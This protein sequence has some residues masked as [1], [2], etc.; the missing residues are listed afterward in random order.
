MSPSDTYTTVL[1]SI[2]LALAGEL[3]EVDRAPKGRRGW[4]S[5]FRATPSA[6]SKQPCFMLEWYPAGEN[7]GSLYVAL[8][9]VR[10]APARLTSD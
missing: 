8:R 4:Q 3:I 5:R 10:S 2:D 6:C 9:A 1:R 7:R